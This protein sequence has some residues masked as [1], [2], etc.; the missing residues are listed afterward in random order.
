MRIPEARDKLWHVIDQLRCIGRDDLAKDC[1]EIAAAM[2]RR[3]KAPEKKSIA[4]RMTPKLKADIRAF[5]DTYPELTQ[6]Q[7]GN[8]FNVNPGRVSEALYGKRH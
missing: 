7:I 6:L 3:R 5:A 4:R 2:Y 8:K 1:V